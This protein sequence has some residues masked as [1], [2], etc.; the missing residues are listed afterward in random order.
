MKRFGVIALSAIVMAAV[1]VPSATL[2]ESSGGGN[3]R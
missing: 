2:A 1:F 3:P